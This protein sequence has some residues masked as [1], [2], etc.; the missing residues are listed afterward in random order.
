[1]EVLSEA[2]A[3]SNELVRQGAK[4]IDE[5]AAGEIPS[6]DKQLAR[7]LSLM[8]SETDPLADRFV[9]DVSFLLGQYR[10][11]CL[12]RFG[13]SPELAR[14]AASLNETQHAAFN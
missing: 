6:A 8:A 13:P 14:T 11:G 3:S 1:M 12:E 7:L 5:F 2:G 9:H 4:I 10:L